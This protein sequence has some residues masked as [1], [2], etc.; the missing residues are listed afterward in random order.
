[1]GEARIALKPQPK[2]PMIS[3]LAL[4]W[5]RLGGLMPGELDE[6]ELAWLVSPHRHLSLLARRRAVLIVNR[7]RLFAFLFAVLTPLWSIVD[8]VV[9]PF[10]LWSELALMRFAA[11]V[12]FACL[13]VCYR[14]NGDLFNA[15]R[16]IALLFAI[17]TVFYVA[18]HTLLTFYQLSGISAAIG[19]GYAF[20]P[21]VLLGG[22][23]IFPL[24]LIETF[25]VAS[26]IL[27]CQAVSG[28][29]RWAAMDWPSFAGAFWLLLLIAGVAGL[30]GIC[31]LAFMIALVRQAIR[32]PLT[33]AFSRNS[34]MELLDLH[35]TNAARAHAPF[36]VAFLDLDRFKNI[37]D[38][39]GHEEGDRALTAMT[40][41]LGHHMRHGDSLVRWGGEEFML[42]MP[43]T[44]LMQAQ[45]AIERL[46]AAGFGT[47]PE[48]G[49]ITAS[50]GIAERK[51][52]RAR[53]WKE[54]VEIADRRMYRA[55]E[56]GRDRVICED[57]PTALSA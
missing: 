25:V 16:A 52:D 51:S 44:S 17:P 32:D 46:R 15:Y 34:G 26:P 39:F 29:L 22:L 6:G 53:E 1:M 21:F 45:V 2:V 31:Q 3:T 4:H 33:G 40:S 8:F 49:P 55:K 18:S 19:A 56:N 13:V 11:C 23:A 7:V 9:F 48:G 27:I 10:Q 42:L 47:R 37:N 5:H 50:V 57:Q 28:Y 35:F 30:A 20:L 43:G 38:E 54:L 12:A 36:S 24:T 41:Q 14:S